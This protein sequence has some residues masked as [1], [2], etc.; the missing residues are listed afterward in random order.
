MAETMQHEDAITLLPWLA[1]GTLDKAER[2]AVRAH[3]IACVLCRRELEAL[4]SVRRSISAAGDAVTLP[5]PDMR[6]INARIDA[7]LSRKTAGRRFAAAL[8]AWTANRWRVAFALQTALLLVLAVV[9]LRPAGVDEASYTT[10]TA[11][12]SRAEGHYLRVIFTPELGGDGLAALLAAH[13]LAV[14]E[15][16]SVRGVY[17]LRFPDGRQDAE[18]SAALAALEHD[19]RV[20]FVQ[21]V[22]G[23]ASP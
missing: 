16:P 15:G 7:V 4:D 1:N 10:L 17:T 23:G 13:D 19:S 12:V 22:A 14:V 11:P 21:P 3:A 8:Q 18:R 2:E 6:C 5:E 9:L 20:L